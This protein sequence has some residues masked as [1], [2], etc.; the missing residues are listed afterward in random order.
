MS[1]FKN[2]VV[3]Q[4]VIGRLD[5][6]FRAQVPKYATSNCS[7]GWLDDFTFVLLEDVAKGLTVFSLTTIK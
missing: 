7:S 6:S 1:E 3:N 5:D 4:N 2:K